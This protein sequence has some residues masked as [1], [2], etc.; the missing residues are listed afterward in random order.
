MV[1]LDLEL[2]TDAIPEIANACHC[3]GLSLA[4]DKVVFVGLCDV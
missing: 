2:E 1:D 3:R 4:H